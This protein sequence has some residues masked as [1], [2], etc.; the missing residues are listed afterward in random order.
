MTDLILLGKI[1]NIYNKCLSEKSISWEN[2]VENIKFKY[3]K[4]KSR[5]GEFYYELHYLDD[6]NNINRLEIIEYE[7]IYAVATYTDNPDVNLFIQ[8]VGGDFSK[9][10]IRLIDTYIRSR[11]LNRV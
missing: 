4:R 11:K 10:C 2:P 6:K 3:V 1:N 5:N 9:D 8:N 7:G